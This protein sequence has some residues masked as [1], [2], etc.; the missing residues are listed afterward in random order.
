MSTTDV[1]GKPAR[2]GALFGKNQPAHY[3]GKPG[4]SG[5]PKGA[6][7]NLR[8]GLRAGRLPKSA[9][10]IEYQ[11]NRFR[12]ELEAAVLAVKGEVTLVDA[13]TIQTALKWERHGALALRWLRTEGESLKPLDRLHFSREIARASTER[14]KAMACLKIDGDAQSEVIDALYSRPDESMKDN[15]DGST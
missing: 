11:A 15:G 8:H 2:G 13:A 10:Y 9:R 3:C 5:P 1:D 6:Q 12:R 7:N 14:D 4:R